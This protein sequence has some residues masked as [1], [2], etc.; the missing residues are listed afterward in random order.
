MLREADVD[1]E[2]TDSIGEM[3]GVVMFDN[4]FS[5][6]GFRGMDMLRVGGRRQRNT[7]VIKKQREAQTAYREVT[8]PNRH[9]CIKAKPQA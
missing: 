6:T 8:L 9:A 2:V 3:L 1:D 4:I 5:T 7:L